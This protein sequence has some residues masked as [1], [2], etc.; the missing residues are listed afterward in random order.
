MDI[1]F[2]QMS[3]RIPE[4]KLRDLTR[5]ASI[6]DQKR[7]NDT[8]MLS[9]FHWEDAGSE[10]RPPSRENRDQ[11]T[12]RAQLSALCTTRD[13]SREVSWDHPALDNLIWWRNHLKE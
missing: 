8:K 7:K 3:F 11:E 12:F 6:S 9:D 2:G 10:R 13:W 1:N 4:Q 5:E